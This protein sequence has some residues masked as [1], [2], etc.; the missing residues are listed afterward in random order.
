M[1]GRHLSPNGMLPRHLHELLLYR[2]VYETI[3]R[4]L[5]TQLNVALSYDGKHFTTLAPQELQIEESVVRYAFGN[6]LAKSVQYDA[7]A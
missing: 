2:S 7:R 4:K 3:A 6:H 1:G 5:P